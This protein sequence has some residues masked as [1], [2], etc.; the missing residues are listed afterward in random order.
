M[1]KN[2]DNN[3]KTSVL[4]L[5]A[6]NSLRMG[7]PKF[8][9]RFDENH[10]FLEKIIER[11]QKFGCDEIIVVLNKQT[12][13]IL[14]KNQSKFIDNKQIAIN[15]FPE[16]ERLLSIQTGLRAFKNPEMVFIHPIDNPFVNF[17]VLES[18]IENC[19]STDYQVPY[20]K[21]KGGHPI[22]I[23]KKIIENICNLMDCDLNFKA[24]LNKFSKISIETDNQEI[25]V[26]INTMNDY[27]SHFK[28]I[29]KNR[30]TN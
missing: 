19:N 14:E 29:N 7:S 4:I 28:E 3:K 26:N 5:A 11:Y 9:L 25:L 2:F 30:Q 24:F 16:R 23:S 6:G 8:M 20:H 18:L 1:K 22:L 21:G 15:P 13:R 17:E 12:A 27:A 10:T